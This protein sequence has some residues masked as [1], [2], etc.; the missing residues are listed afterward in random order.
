MELQIKSWEDWKEMERL[1]WTRFITFLPRH[2]RN[3]RQ[4]EI[5]SLHNPEGQMRPCAE[6]GN[7]TKFYVGKLNTCDQDLKRKEQS[8]PHLGRGLQVI[9]QLEGPWRQSAQTCVGLLC[10]ERSVKSLRKVQ[11][12][13]VWGKLHPYHVFPNC[14]GQISGH[15]Q[16]QQFALP[17]AYLGTRREV[18]E[19]HSSDHP[20]AGISS[21]WMAGGVALCFFFCSVFFLFHRV[22]ATIL[23]LNFCFTFKC[24]PLFC[25]LWVFS[26]FN[27]S[28]SY[29]FFS[30]FIFLILVSP[31][32]SSAFMR[33]KQ[34]VPGHE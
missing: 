1:R 18:R 32:F 23:K 12:N 34:Q 13:Q 11:R 29:S 25:C 9:Y 21:P 20:K 24:F 5:L 14:G 6:P 4:C 33:H 31:L 3:L 2:W 26:L 8:P 28:P 17:K 19:T 7:C 10:S 30:T 16:G 15:R 22:L 27:F